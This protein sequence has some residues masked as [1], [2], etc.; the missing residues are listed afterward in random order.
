MPT[1]KVDPFSVDFV[2][3]EHQGSIFIARIGPFLYTI[4][5]FQINNTTFNGCNKRRRICII[6]ITMMRRIYEKKG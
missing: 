3:Y 6:L 5:L 4:R 2:I 1:V